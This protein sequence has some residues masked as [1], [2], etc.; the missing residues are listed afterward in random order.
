M[1]RNSLEDFI[2]YSQ[3]C[4]FSISN[5]G[6]FCKIFQNMTFH[7]AKTNPMLRSLHFETESGTVSFRHWLKSSSE[8]SNQPFFAPLNWHTGQNN[9]PEIRRLNYRAKRTVLMSPRFATCPTL[10]GIGSCLPGCGSP[11][12]LTAASRKLQKSPKS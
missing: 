4:D 1:A 5:Y 12:F 9:G 8:T 3:I 2:K 6:R 11:A 7:F 10:S